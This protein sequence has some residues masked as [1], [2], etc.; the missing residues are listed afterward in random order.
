MSKKC[1]VSSSIEQRQ[2]EQCNC[3][4]SCG[5]GTCVLSP[6]CIHI[7]N[8]LKVAVIGILCKLVPL[9]VTTAGSN[10]QDIEYKYSVGHK[11]L[12]LAKKKKFL[13]ICGLHAYRGSYA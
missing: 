7:T 12:K 13:T 1:N 3:N 9:R 8:I 10:L 2:Q 11:K 5:A 4:Q 6:L